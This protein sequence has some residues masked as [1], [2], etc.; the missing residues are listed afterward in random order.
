MNK[1]AVYTLVFYLDFMPIYEIC[2]EL[3]ERETPF[4]RVFEHPLKI[5]WNS[6]CIMQ[7]IVSMMWPN[8]SLHQHY[9]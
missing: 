2:W 4:S 7:A 3:E 9:H 1:F 6:Y 8:D 5:P